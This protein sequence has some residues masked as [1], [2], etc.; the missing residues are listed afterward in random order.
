MFWPRLNGSAV[1]KLS[2]KTPVPG[3]VASQSDDESVLDPAAEAEWQ[4]LRRQIEFATEFW[5]GFIFCPSPLPVA[6]LRRRAEQLYQLQ[7]TQVQLVRPTRP[8][9]LRD[10]LPRLLAPEYAAAGCIWVE[11]VHL[12]ASTFTDDV[13]GPWAE[14]WDWTLMRTNEHREVL[15][16]RLNGG[17]VYA[18]PPQ[19]KPRTRNAAPDLWSIRALV[20]DLPARDGRQGANRLDTLKGQSTLPDSRAGTAP[21]VDFALAE[22]RR[23]KGKQRY[24]PLSHARTLLRAVEGLLAQDQDGAASKAVARAH[25]ALDILRA[26]PDPGRLLAEALVWAGAAER[27][28]GDLAAAAE[29]LSESVRG[30]KSILETHGESAPTV[31]ALS[32]SLN[33]IG[34]VQRDSGDLSTAT[35]AFEESLAL[36]R[37]LLEVYGETPQGLRDLSISLS[38]VGDVRLESGDLSMATAAFEESL[39]LSRRLLEKYGETPQGLRD[40]SISLHRIGD[41]RRESGD[42]SMATAAFE[43]S[44][45]LSRRLLEVYGETPQGLRDLSISLDRIGDVRLES[46]DLSAATAAFEES[47][48]LNRRLLEA[49]GETPQGLRDLSVGLNGIGDVRRELGDL[50]A[51]TAAFEEWVSLSRRLL[52]AYGETPQGLRDLSVGLNRIGDMRRELGDLSAATTAFEESL[53]LDRRLLEV[54]GETPQR[55][56]DLCASLV[57]LANMRRECGDSAAATCALQE[58]RDIERRLHLMTT[59]T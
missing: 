1:P 6:A 41:V 47:L 38:K 40:M 42:L 48:V 17:L 11:A 43:E 3:H 34:D 56:R 39:A 28:D 45:A 29:H 27:A 5:L 31:R 35:A 10:L 19:W 24:D 46:G 36:N 23:I 7:G 18:V 52:E 32:F 50:S 44:L 2:S 33:G 51:A 53:A 12:D 57:G 59:A 30:W 37:R 55:L 25:E 9:E 22:A 54:Y 20:V 8:G 49:Y 58:S 15:R 16:R 26:V 14:A 13:P 4:V 21:D